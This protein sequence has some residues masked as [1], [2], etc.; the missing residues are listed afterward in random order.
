VAY[1]ELVAGTSI[2]YNLSANA[3]SSLATTYPSGSASG[4]LLFMQCQV[5]RGA[6]GSFTLNTPSGGGTW[7]LIGSQND[8][9]ANGTRI[10]YYYCYRGSETS[11]TVQASDTSFMRNYDVTLVAFKASTVQASSPIGTHQITYA[12]ADSASAVTTASVTAPTND[13]YTLV[14]SSWIGTFNTA[15]ATAFT[16][17]IT[18]VADNSAYNASTAHMYN[19]AV[20]YHQMS[21]SGSTQAYTATPSRS[22]AKRIIAAIPIK[23]LAASTINV[24]DTATLTDTAGVRNVASDTATLTD[25]ASVT[26]SFPAADTVSFVEANAGI[27]VVVTEAITYSDIATQRIVVTDSATWTENSTLWIVAADT[28]TW[29]DTASIE[30]TTDATDTATLTDTAAV[31]PSASDSATWTDNATIEADTPAADSATLSDTASVRIQATDTISFIDDAYASQTQQQADT[32]ALTDDASIRNQ[33]TDSATFTEGATVIVQGADTVGWVNEDAIVTN[34]VVVEDNWS[35]TDTADDVPATEIPASDIV[36]FTDTAS[37]RNTAADSWTFT[38]LVT[39][40]RVA[41]T[42]SSSFADALVSIRVSATDTATVT[43]DAH[44]ATT[45]N[46]TDSISFTDTVFRVLVAGSDAATFT[47]A[48]LPMRIDTD[49]DWGWDDSATNYGDGLNLEGPRVIRVQPAPSRFM[50]VRGDARRAVVPASP[51]R[52]MTVAKSLNR[53]SVVPP[54]PRRTMM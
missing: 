32:A 52:H 10:D 44:S 20:G 17:P 21:T 28:A 26:A 18:E 42:D 27:R 16:S 11:V 23:A 5:T 3:A 7:T 14:F 47:D 6:N 54:G 37:I 1:P 13:T 12:A 50:V 53:N 36:G 2:V 46:A 51:S 41:V 15:L 31:R 8:T 22:A 35:F 38:D 45:I 24:T 43:D 9:V 33:V 30:A 34:S 49:D 25:T 4:D 19:D 48:V 39:T 29:S 40:V